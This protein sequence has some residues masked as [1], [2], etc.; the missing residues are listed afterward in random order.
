[1][2]LWGAWRTI[3]RSVGRKGIAPWNGTFIRPG[4]LMDW[5]N[6]LDFKIDRAQYSIYRPPVSRYLGEVNDYSDGVSRTMNLPIGSVYVIVARKHVGA[7]LSIK[8]A[9]NRHQ[10]FGRLSAVRSVRHDGPMSLEHDSA[11]Q[12]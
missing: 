4:R 12:K 11:A 6:L 8:P 9:W 1:M 2:S 5:L 3:A 7:A 10:A